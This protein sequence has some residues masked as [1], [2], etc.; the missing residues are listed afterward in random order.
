[1]NLPSIVVIARH[2][3]EKPTFAN[4]DEDWPGCFACGYTGHHGNR[5]RPLSIEI[6]WKLSRLERCH[7]IGAAEGGGNDVSNLV[8]LCK[9]CHKDA[10]TIGRTAQPMIDWIN[11]REGYTTWFWDRLLAECAAIS[12]TLM[13]DLNSAE[14]QNG[15]ELTAALD[16]MAKFMK[17]GY[18]PD[19]NQFATL[20]ALF[21]GIVA[22]KTILREGRNG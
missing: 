18:H 11:R 21:E 1:M 15:E 13:A 10:P 22:L 3:M 4:L 5:D 19:G 7:L 20:A 8:L 14:W 12:P 6:Q 16:A 2:W 9:R 17:V